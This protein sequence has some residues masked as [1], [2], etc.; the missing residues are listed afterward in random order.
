MGI[1][2]TINDTW[3]VTLDELLTQLP[4]SAAA[5]EVAN[6]RGEL[7]MYKK[8]GHIQIW[9]EQKA[10]ITRL[11]EALSTGVPILEQAANRIEKLEG[12]LKDSMQ[13]CLLEDMDGDPLNIHLAREINTL[14]TESV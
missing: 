13:F 10:E 14:L 1:R 11:N 3:A 6:I 8:A 5:K 7:E 12:L 9:R 2:M 4:N